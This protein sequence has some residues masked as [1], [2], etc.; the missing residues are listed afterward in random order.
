M[1]VQETA[2]A[3][4]EMVRSGKAKHIGVSNF[5]PS[6]F[7]LLDARMDK[8][9]VTNQ[10][11]MSVLEMAP[12]EDGVMDQAMR[13]GFSPMA[14]SPL[15]GGLLFDEQNE[16]SVRVRQTLKVLGEKYEA[17]VATMALAWLL[18][19][20]AR[21][22]PIIGSNSPERIRSLVKAEKV[23]LTRTEWFEV[24]QAS[25]GREVP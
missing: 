24:W 13:L 9:L 18:A 3:L 14:W 22:V 12:L 8:P 11:E 5:T 16:A 10:I 2:S 4:N 7:Q 17:D 20:P 6:Q 25:K 1:D 23:A 15:G 21:I 19:H